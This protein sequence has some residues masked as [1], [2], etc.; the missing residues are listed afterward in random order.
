[1]PTQLPVALRR[2]EVKESETKSSVSF[3]NHQ[4]FSIYLHY[5]VLHSILIN[6]GIGVMF[7]FN[8]YSFELNKLQKKLFV[9]QKSQRIK[10]RLRRINRWR[11][12]EVF[13]DIYVFDQNREQQQIDK[14]ET[15]FFQAI[16]TVATKASSE[17]F[18]TDS[19]TDFWVIS[20]K[21]ATLRSTH[22]FQEEFDQ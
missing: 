21:I 9:H 11:R 20:T 3:K 14:S 12:A 7:S 13:G 10:S 8:S 2:N 18:A 1:M 15:V 4:E 17:I 22:L 16:K 5:Q 19:T 6:I